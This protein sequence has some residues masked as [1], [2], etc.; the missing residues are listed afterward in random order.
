MKQCFAVGN[1]DPSFEHR[2][3]ERLG[4]LHELAESN[5]TTRDALRLSS[6]VI[7]ERIEAPSHQL[8]RNEKKV[9]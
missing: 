9:D 6:I 4:W 1:Y 8:F 3:L 5:K 7:E 2:N